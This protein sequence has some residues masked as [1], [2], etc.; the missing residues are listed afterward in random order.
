MKQAFLAQCKTNLAH[1]NWSGINSTGLAFSIVTG[2][3]KNPE[4]GPIWVV[5]PNEA[6][7]EKL[8]ESLLFFTKFC[9]TNIEVGHYI[10]D[11]PRTFDGASPSPLCPRKR[12]HA[13]SLLFQKNSIVVSSVLG[14]LHKTLDKEDTYQQSIR[15]KIGLEYPKNH[16]VMKTNKK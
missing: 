4:I 16:K 10:Q 7:C 3:K 6:R 14:C 15:L 8:I 13:R 1:N 2:L 5:C 9:N 12:I 11:D